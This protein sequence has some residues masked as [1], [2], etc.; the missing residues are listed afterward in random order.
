MGILSRNNV[1]FFSVKKVITEIKIYYENETVS[2]PLWVSSG[3]C[4]THKHVL[5]ISPATVSHFSFIYN[6]FVVCVCV[7]LKKISL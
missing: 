5:Q 7:C 6:V 3:S 4:S 2:T 1:H